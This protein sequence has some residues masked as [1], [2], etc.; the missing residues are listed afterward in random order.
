MQTAIDLGIGH[1]ILETDAHEKSESS[2]FKKHMIV[3]L[4]AT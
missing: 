3:L 4:L 1:I 2:E